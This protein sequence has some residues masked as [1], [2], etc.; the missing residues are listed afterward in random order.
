MIV[1]L[2]LVF[3]KGVVASL[4]PFVRMLFPSYFLFLISQLNKFLWFSFLTLLT[5]SLTVY[6]SLHFVLKTRILLTSLQLID[7][8]SNIPPTCLY[9]VVT[10]T[11]RIYPGQMIP[12]NYV[13][14]VHPPTPIIL[15]PNVLT[16]LF[17]T[18]K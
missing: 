2:L 9:L 10:T 17:F 4:L 16:A 8:S 14:L 13:T 3:V 12:V 15:F 6:N 5:L 18:I 11:F 1:L 7:F